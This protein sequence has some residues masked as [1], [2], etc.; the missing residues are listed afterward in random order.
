MAYRSEEKFIL[1]K[2]I[3]VED[4]V[5]DDDTEQNKSLALNGAECGAEA[6]MW[7]ACAWHTPSVLPLKEWRCGSRMTSGIF[8]RKLYNEIVYPWAHTRDDV[9]LAH[10][11]SAGHAADPYLLL[12]SFFKF[13]VTAA[14]VRCNL[15]AVGNSSN[16]QIWF[17]HNSR[18]FI[19]AKVPQ[20]SN[21]TCYFPASRADAEWFA[22]IFLAFVK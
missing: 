9:S 3:L 22:K 7:E 8:N 15:F 17:Q 18:H 4:D 13:Q 14:N 21:R 12:F 20:Q 16:R 11:T 6:W 10:A 5:D 1:K 2:I 19:G